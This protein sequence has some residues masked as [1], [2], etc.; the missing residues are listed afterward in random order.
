[1]EAIRLSRPRKILLSMDE[2]DTLGGISPEAHQVF[3][4]CWDEG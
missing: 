2:E 3:G 4:T 1:M